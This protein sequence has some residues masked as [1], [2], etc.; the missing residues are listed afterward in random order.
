MWGGDILFEDGKLRLEARLDLLEMT[1]VY[2]RKSST[3]LKHNRIVKKVVPSSLFFFFIWMTVRCILQSDNHP[4][5]Q[6]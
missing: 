6:H 1:D 5:H 4:L 3:L 2:L